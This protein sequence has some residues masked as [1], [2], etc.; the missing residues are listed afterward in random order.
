MEERK[1]G[2]QFRKIPHCLMGTASGEDESGAWGAR[3][4]EIHS[5]TTVA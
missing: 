5:E 3:A 2:L 1:W 4:A